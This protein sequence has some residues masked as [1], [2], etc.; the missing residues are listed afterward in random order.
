MPRPFR[1]PFSPVVPAIGILLCVYLMAQLPFTTW[2]RFF[3]W[4]AAGVL[5]YVRYGYRHSRPRQAAVEQVGTERRA[6]GRS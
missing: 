3:G 4:L 1:V 6:Q 2:V 5:S